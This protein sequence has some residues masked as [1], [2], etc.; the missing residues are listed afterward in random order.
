[1]SERVKVTLGPTYENECQGKVKY[2]SKGI[3]RKI[4]R[5]M[6]KAHHYRFNVYTCNYCGFV[7]VGNRQRKPK[8]YIPRL[9]DMFV[10]YS[11]ASNADEVDD[12]DD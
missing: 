12:L 8:E 4:R 9:G 1:M 11:L 7:H 3:G 2:R 6:Q 10:D 5:K